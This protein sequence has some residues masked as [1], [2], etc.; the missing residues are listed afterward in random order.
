MPI[1]LWISVEHSPAVNR[2]FSSSEVV[3]NDFVIWR[4]GAAMAQ[5]D[6]ERMAQ[7]TES[8]ETTDAEILRGVGCFRWPSGGS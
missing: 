8:I 2:T 1:T 6:S 3:L 4:L 7:S 5:T